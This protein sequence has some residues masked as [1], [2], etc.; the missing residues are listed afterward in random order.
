MGPAQIRVGT[1]KTRWAQGWKTI[2]KEPSHLPK[3]LST[4]PWWQS[5]DALFGSTGVGCF[6]LSRNER[7]LGS[8][9]R[10]HWWRC[11][12]QGGGERVWGWLRG[13]GHYKSMISVGIF[14]WQ[15]EWQL[16]TQEA[17]DTSTGGLSVLPKGISCAFWRPR[18][19]L[20]DVTAEQYS[21]S[22]REWKF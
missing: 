22:T 16:A 11:T 15:L 12:W 4:L 18:Q 9:F 20:A 19:K 1:S 7:H 14:R 2:S 17:E 8:T 6:G 13:S 21:F 5:R 10:R 3:L